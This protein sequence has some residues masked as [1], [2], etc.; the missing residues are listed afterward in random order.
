[1]SC[2]VVSC[3]I[4][5]YRIVLLTILYVS[6]VLDAFIWKYQ[7]KKLPL[8]LVHFSYPPRHPAFLPFFL[9]L[10]P[11]DRCLTE[12]SCLVAQRIELVH[13]YWNMLNLEQNALKGKWQKNSR[14]NFSSLFL[15]LFLRFCFFLLF[16]IIKVGF[17]V[18]KLELSWTAQ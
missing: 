6:S 9:V 2:C 18:K 16:S 13:L 4:V 3:R 7:C 15:F 1:M 11:V 17:K 8:A 14:V 5:S 12:E 10:F